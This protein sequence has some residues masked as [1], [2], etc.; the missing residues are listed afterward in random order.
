[1]NRRYVFLFAGVI[2]AAGL[3]SLLGRMPGPRPEA[4]APTAAAP[5]ASLEL[6]IDGTQVMPVATQA[7][8]DHEVDLVV[9]NR[10]AQ[11]AEL[12]LSGYEDRVGIRVEPGGRES[13]AFLA[14]RPGDGFAWLV[15]GQPAGRFVV[16]GSH[17]VE[18]HR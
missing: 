11:P 18:G 9:V 13:L 3:I 15:D 7:P 17:L 6:T 10:G 8:K 12:T 14:D 5:R 2:L 4:P 1:V 16:S